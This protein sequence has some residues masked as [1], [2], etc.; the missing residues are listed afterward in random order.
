MTYRM[1]PFAIAAVCVA[2][3]A[4]GCSSGGA[5]E[6]PPTP[7]SP[8]V[9]T[10]ENPP[11]PGSAT[12]AAD[13][14]TPGDPSQSGDPSPSGDPSQSGEPGQDVTLQTGQTAHLQYFDVTVL[15][16]E[17][18]QDGVSAGWKVRVCYTRGHPG[19]NPDGTTRVSRD[20]WSVSVRDGEGAEPAQWQ[21]L[22]DFEHDT[23]WTP[24]YTEKQ[25]R[26]GECNEGWLGIKHGSPDLVFDGIRYAPADFEGAAT[27][28]Q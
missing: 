14:S 9:L 15:R 4:T 6:K 23:T 25:L 18:G 2:A 13:A 17:F 24:D 5:E 8:A 26:V 22:G 21:P 19:A 1:G 27:W 11:A 16:F 28:R 3:L 12:P 20:P 7:P 10:P